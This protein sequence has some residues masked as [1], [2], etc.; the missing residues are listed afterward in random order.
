M[1]YRW[2][3]SWRE[4]RSYAVKLLSIQDG[5]VTLIPAEHGRN[6]RER[7]T[8]RRMETEREKEEK[9]GKYYVEMQFALCL[10]YFSLPPWILYNTSVA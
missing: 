4:C 5:E 2:Q 9:K 10:K 6:T 3:W 1:I 7:K 8:D